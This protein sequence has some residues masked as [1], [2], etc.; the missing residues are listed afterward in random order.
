MKAVKGASR[1]ETF[2]IIRL[3]RV[4]QR[5][6]V[7]NN[8]VLHGCADE[9]SPKKSEVRLAQV[10]VLTF[11]YGACFLGRSSPS[12]TASVLARFHNGNQGIQFHVAVTSLRI[13]SNV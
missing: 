5:D 2:A 10:R 7:V 11:L 9:I 13:F 1:I 6:D 3:Q 4:L 12:A 8:E